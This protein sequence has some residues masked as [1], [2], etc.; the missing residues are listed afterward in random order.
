MFIKLFSKNV[1]K[2]KKILI[3]QD[4]VFKTSKLVDNILNY[5]NKLALRGGKKEITYSLKPYRTIHKEEIKAAN[6]VLRSGILSGFEA[7]KTN[8][9]F[10]GKKLKILNKKLKTSLK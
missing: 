9:F 2:R 5:E 6:E 10:G 7:S 1:K 4:S 3:T 8:N